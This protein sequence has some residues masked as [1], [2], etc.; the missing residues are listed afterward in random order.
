MT[1]WL[2]QSISLSGGFGFCPSLVGA[3]RVLQNCG[4]HG[5]LQQI[6]CETSFRRFH[7][8][9]CQNQDTLFAAYSI[10]SFLFLIASNASAQT[11]SSDPV[12]TTIITNQPPV[13]TVSQ[14]NKVAV[15]KKE[16]DRIRRFNPNAGNTAKKNSVRASKEVTI[17]PPHNV[18]ASS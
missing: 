12:T 17:Q 15:P 2:S 1:D 4:D 10:S 8:Q 18:L 16:M 7:H 13:T 5:F 11:P 6:L 3:G 9:T 14:T